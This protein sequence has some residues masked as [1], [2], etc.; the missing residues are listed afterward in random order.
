MSVKQIFTRSCI[1]TN[2][3][4]AGKFVCPG[5]DDSMLTDEQNK[6]SEHGCKINLYTIMYLYKCR[7]PGK[8]VYP[9]LEDLMSKDDKTSVVNPKV[10]QVCMSWLG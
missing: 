7:K 6:R 8:F 5:L 3:E 4:S 9:G 10:R 1:N 2:A